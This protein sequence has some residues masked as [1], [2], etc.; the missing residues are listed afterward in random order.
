MSGINRIILADLVKKGGDV[1]SK[2]SP[3]NIR[4]NAR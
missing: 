3:S 1:I 2:F 4:K